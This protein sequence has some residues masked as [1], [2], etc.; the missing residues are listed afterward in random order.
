MSKAAISLIPW[1]LLD[2]A[3][4]PGGGDDKLRLYQRGTD[5]SIRI[6]QSEL[7]NSREHYSEEV[8]AELACDHVR[9][10][11]QAR[12]LIGGLGM[13][14]TLAAALP[15]LKKDASIVVSELI[16]EVVRWNQEE[17][18]G[19]TGHPLRDSR[20]AVYNEDVGAVMRRERDGFD[21]IMLDVDNG[22]EGFTRESNDAL[23]GRKG[24]TTA[25]NSLRAG[26]VLTVWSATPSKAF[27]EH[28]ERQNFMV[29]TITTR[30]RN[31]EKGAY[32]TVWFAVRN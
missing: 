25:F 26:G 5:F 15:R 11:K 24:I 10:R 13:G 17:L 4:V 9:E 22:P 20:V 27:G 7:M 23:Y 2:V 29:Q 32:H 28:L 14:F 19:L 3:P 30:S 31:A 16:P 8:L 1:V 12:V 18:G 21:A 6:D